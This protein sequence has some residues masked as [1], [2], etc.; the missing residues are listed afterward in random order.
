MLRVLSITII[1]I[2]LDL[3]KSLIFLEFILFTLFPVIKITGNSGS[4]LADS[5]HRT[6]V[7]SEPTERSFA[8]ALGNPT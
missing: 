2:R 6:S 5:K 4:L 1:K 8:A 3:P 7:R